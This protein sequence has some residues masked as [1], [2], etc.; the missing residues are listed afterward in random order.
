MVV[1]KIHLSWRKGKGYERR[2]I[3]EIYRF[4]GMGYNFKYLKEGVED[5][6]KEGFINYPEFPDSSDWNFVYTEGIKEIFSLR[7]I[8]EGRSDRK[9]YL[10]F[11]EADKSEYDWFDQLALTQGMLSTDNFEFLG[12]YNPPKINSFVTDVANLS[13][14]NLAKDTI[15]TDDTLTYKIEDTIYDFNGKCVKLFHNGYE[16]GFIKKIHNIFFWEAENR[17]FTP[18]VK[19][20]AID[21]NGNIKQIY[22]KVYL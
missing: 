12:I 21:Q 20:K 16:I 7:L 2:I 14:R 5:A 18:K 4:G 6:K 22:V 17:G 9:Q 11:W 1:T 13:K 15:M 19:I 8:P 10:A 3:G